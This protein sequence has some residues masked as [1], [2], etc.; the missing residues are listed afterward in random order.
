M[1][2]NELTG[3]RSHPAYKQAR[4][5]FD[6]TTDKWAMQTR[7]KDKLEQFRTFLEQNGFKFIDKGSFGAVF[8]RPG[9]PWVFKIFTRDP[10]YLHFVKYA[11][12]H[13]GNPH[14]PRIKGIIKINDDTYA[15][16][17]ERLSPIP[18]GT[19]PAMS[20]IRKI[21]GI[22]SYGDLSDADAAW[23]DKT[24]PGISAFF[25]SFPLRDFEYDLRLQNFMQRG[26]TMVIVDPIYV[27]R[28]MQ[29]N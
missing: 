13:Q 28:E 16:R 27:Y 3:Y 14:L 17:M 12:A 24:F 4:S 20:L 22:D 10:A 2:I 19:E 25:K 9:Y 5:T 23:I 18:L 29:G 8:E 21:V 7:R 11:M 26:N 6:D 15:V 1:R